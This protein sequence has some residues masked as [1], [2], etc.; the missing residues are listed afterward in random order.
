MNATATP[1]KIPVVTLAK[2]EYNERFSQETNCFSAD[3]LVDGVPIGRVGNSGTGGGDDYFPF[4]VCDRLD[5]IA[6][7]MPLLYP[8]EKWENNA[9]LLVGVIF[10]DWLANRDL[11]RALKKKVV[12]TTAE[13]KIFTATGFKG[14]E[15][16]QLLAKGEAVLKAEFPKAVKILNLL[17]YEE[18]LA[19]Y[20]AG[21]ARA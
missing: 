18:A 1:T 9:E 11:K 13:G 4:S 16:A 5:E 14:D 21:T 3:V 2:V 7:M 19:A 8:E 20:K 6:K 12:F 15:L 10:A 17:P